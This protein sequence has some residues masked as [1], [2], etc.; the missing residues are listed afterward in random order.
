[1]QGNLN[2]G[3]K[4]M[5]KEKKSQKEFLGNIW[6]VNTLI[7]KKIEVYLKKKLMEN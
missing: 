6:Y 3:H 7:V 4:N 1:M 5:E 2:E